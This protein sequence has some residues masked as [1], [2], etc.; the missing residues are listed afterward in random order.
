MSRSTVLHLEADL[1]GQV[2]LKAAQSFQDYPDNRRQQP[3]SVVTLPCNVVSIDDH[4]HPLGMPLVAV[5]TDISTGGVSLLLQQA[6]KP[7]RVRISITRPGQQPLQLTAAI[8]RCHE[9]DEG[10]FRIGAR[11]LNKV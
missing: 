10:L 1:P 11:L 8:T 2:L 9:I 3:R 4:D 7:Q 5:T 6:M